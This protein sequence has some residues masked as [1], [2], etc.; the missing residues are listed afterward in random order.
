VKILFL[1]PEDSPDRGPWADQ[2]WNRVIDLGAA[3]PSSYQ[4]WTEK[5]HCPV[6]P[7]QSPGNGMDEIRMLREL[8]AV[9]RGRLLDRQGLDWWELNSVFLEQQL[10]TTAMLSQV[11][12]LIGGNDQVSVT[13]PGFHADVLSVVLGRDVHSFAPEASRWRELG[14]YAT[15]ARKFPLSQLQE[16]F[17]DKYDPAYEFRG[18]FRRRRAPSKTPV[19]L[20]PSAYVNVSRIAIAYANTL[21][22]ENFLLVATRQSGWVTAP[23]ANVNVARLSSYASSRTESAQEC[24]ELLEKWQDLLRDLQSSFPEVAVLA[25]LKIFDQF[26]RL[27]RLGLGVRDAWRNVFEREPLKAVLC[28]DDGNPY[29]C[30]PLLL[31]RNQGMPTVACHHGALD[32]RH[33]FKR[34]HAGVILAKGAME[35]DYLVRVC[36]VP[37]ESVE[38]GAPAQ[39]PLRSV[40]KTWDSSAPQIVFFSEPYE[41]AGGRGEEYFCEL[42]PPLADLAMQTGRKLIVKL[43][44][45]ESERERNRVASRVLSAEQRPHVKVMSGPLAP[46]LLDDMWFGVTVGSTAAVECAL[47]GR[48]CFLCEWL[49]FGRYGY[50]QQFARFGVGYPLKSADDIARV[51]QV[52]ESYPGS[53]RKTSDLW[54]PIQAETLQSLLREPRRLPRYA[55]S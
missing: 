51:P 3:G 18:R 36:G 49:P 34:N 16:I 9:G 23:P 53:K 47:A 55:A 29:T 26:S 8:L 42:L 35:E 17:W 45:F 40:R 39:T 20:L 13:K 48:P 6:E 52:L 46:D 37:P 43:H 1:H 25:R 7:L 28:G 21:P 10:T 38:T 12:S 54:Q 31:A 33:L 50:Q 11:T 32:G 2:T 4:A 15:V 5:L 24:S 41:A 30:I 22:D 19:V 27:L 14:H 44:A